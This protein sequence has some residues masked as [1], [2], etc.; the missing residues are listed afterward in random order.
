M[1]KISFYEQ[2]S[3]N[4]RNSIFLTIV[5]A[6]ILLGL[7]YVIALLYNPSMVY[8]FLIFGSIVTLGHILIS[9]NVGDKIILKAMNAVPADEVKHRYIIDT[10]DGLSIAAG[11]PK[12]KVYIVDSKEINA[13]AT[14]KD[15]KHASIALTTGAI[16]KLKRDEIE[17]VI[18]HEISHIANYD[19]R[20]ATLVAALVGMIA[21][22]SYMILRSWRFSGSS[23]ENRGGIVWLIAIGLILAIF[24]PIV[25]RIVQAAISRKRE[26]M[27]DANS[28]K[29]TRYPDGLA[30]AL[31]KI[32]KFNEGRMQV[33]ESI[34]HLF[35]TDPNKS[36]LDHLFATHPDIDKRIE[37]LRKM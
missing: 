27:A 30:N 16:E 32:K 12:P 7:F 9:Y 29:L 22:I 6:A 31:E 4:K 20:F 35:F 8:I 11:L 23:R 13:F 36:P 18:G 33:S 37:I 34:S 2:I 25:S 10:V 21:I 3:K 28:A 5:V 24:A 15:P 1:D 19:I 14:G 26:F 17:G